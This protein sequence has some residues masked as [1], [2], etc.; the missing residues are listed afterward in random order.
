MDIKKLF[1]KLIHDR[2][3]LFYIDDYLAIKN[4]RWY[5][6]IPAGDS[7]LVHDLRGITPKSFNFDFIH[8]RIT[9]SYG[10]WENQIYNNDVEAEQA[11]LA[12]AIHYNEMYFQMVKEQYNKQVE[13]TLNNLD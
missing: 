6:A 1:K 3:D 12:S 2:P 8:D 10:E 7:V 9:L 4:C 5:I 13:Q 11:I